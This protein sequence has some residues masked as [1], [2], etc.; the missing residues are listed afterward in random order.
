MVIPK[1]KEC[2]PLV[3]GI[4]KHIDYEFPEEFSLTSSQLDTIFLSNWSQR[5]AAPVLR[6]VHNDETTTML[7]QAELETLAGLINGMYKHR[8]DKLMD[9]ALAEY[10]PIHNYYDELTE[11]TE[12]GEGVTHSKTA[13]GS[14]S[15]TRTDNLTDTKTDGR[16]I[17]ETRNLQNSGTNSSENGIYGFNS[18]SAVGDTTSSGSNSNSETGTVTTGHAGNITETNTGTQSNSGTTSS[19]ESG[20]DETTGTKSRTYTKTGNIGNIS[21]QKLLNEELE[22]WQ[23]NFV[24]EMMR[25]VINFVSLPT[26]ET[27]NF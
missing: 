13:G 14:S 19:T 15:N 21:T 7:T 2:L 12:Y 16:T 26:Y 18:S 24:Y 6:V 11:S 3:D 10:D 8:W 5:L 4:W 9:V 1:I 23:Y 22:L 27:D 17:T 25:D 20:S